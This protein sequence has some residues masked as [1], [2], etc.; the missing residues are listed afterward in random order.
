MKKPSSIPEETMDLIPVNFLFLTGI[1]KKIF[2]NVRL[3]GSWDR[4]GNYSSAWTEADMIPGSGEDGCTAFNATIHL[5]PGEAGTTFSWGLLFD[6]PSGNAVWGVP[7]E[8][9][10]TN[11]TLRT[12]NFVLQ[13]LAAAA[14]GP[15][16]EERYYLT[17][18]RHFGAQKIFPAGSKSPALQFSVWAPNAIAVNVVFGSWQ[19]GYIDDNGGGI[20]PAM[21]VV[22][23]RN[24]GSGIWKSDVTTSP[25]LSDFLAF[26]HA[27]YMFRIRRA[28]G[29]IAYRTDIYSRCQIGAGAFDPAGA[30]YTGTIAELN[31][32]VSC[33]V[34]IDP[35]TVT[36]KLKPV[37]WPA[38]KA[39]LIP[40]S[41]FW[42]DEFDPKHPLPARI[43]DLVIYELHIASL[44]FGRPTPGDFADAI[45][46]LDSQLIPLG[47]NAVELLPVADSAGNNEWG[48]GN[49]HYFAVEFRTGGR[50]HLKHFVRACHQRGIAVILDVVYNHFNPNRERAEGHYD[51]DAPNDDIYLWYEGLPGQ[52]QNPD[53]GYLY[54]GS[55][56]CVP[57]YWEEYVRK[58]FVSSAAMLSEEFHVDG[59]RVDLTQAMH[60]DCRLNA[61]HELVPS[62]N[63]FGGKLLRE[64][65]RT[66]KAIRP[67]LFL[68]AEEHE[69]RV[70]IT[71]PADS[72]G[73]GFDATWFVDIYHNT[74]GVAADNWA[75]LVAR[76]GI[77]NDDP[78]RFDWLSGSLGWTGNKTISYHISH[79]ECGNSGSDAQNPDLRSHRTMVQ[80][81]HGVQYVA[82]N[83][84]YAEAR[85][86]FA[87]GM[88]ALSAGAPMFFMAEEIGALQD[89][90]YNDF[91]NRRE[92]IAGARLGSGAHLFR[93]YSDLI[94]FRKT[95]TALRSL[96]IAIL[97]RREAERIIVFRR[98]SDQE[99][100]L[101]FATLSNR[102]YSNGYWVYASDL[103]DAAWREV[104]NSDSQFYGGDNVGNNGGQV[105]SHGG[106]IGPVVPA[107]GFV[108]LRR[109]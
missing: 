96:D 52:Y 80:A 7:T 32:R 43:E 49:T 91:L 58:M 101:I 106:Y 45:A 41:Q 22:P 15:V 28:N 9:H 102:P 79:D 23:L 11:S 66:L 50:D 2:R 33:S 57:R 34:V 98:M 70:Q 109:I 5:A 84:E 36:S 68:I 16:Q 100:L 55:T 99:D 12:R 40:E 59:F 60:A 20:D 26:D 77:G 83:R 13:P 90:K 82:S 1:K 14:N 95:S 76:A 85:S 105:L 81:V 78:L 87:F 92:D 3:T 17:D 94:A 88:A 30:P 29:T 103:P 56:D 24:N 62:A 19:N 48:Y 65:T 63:A 54:N 72:G 93:F 108:V 39:L 37:E 4:N 107:K 75:G 10:D 38:D 44:G 67:S 74:V 35:D 69:D 42:K 61:T 104:F 8:V 89:Y 86:R 46:F 25:R 47:V 73:F 71:Q 18:S 51:S 6:G 31:G 27:P 21:P 97:D 53:D 64:W